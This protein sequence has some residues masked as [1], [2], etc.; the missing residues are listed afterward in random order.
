M[1]KVSAICQEQPGGAAKSFLTGRRLATPK[2][3][4][5]SVV[6]SYET[7]WRLAD[8]QGNRELGNQCRQVRDFGQAVGHAPSHADRP[9]DTWA[10]GP[11]AMLDSAPEAVALRC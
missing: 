3:S 7:A 6:Q 10:L 4:R 1:W 2:L 5:A 9:N 8:A 11:D